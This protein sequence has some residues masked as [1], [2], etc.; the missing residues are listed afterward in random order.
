MKKYIVHEVRGGLMEDPSFHYHNPEEIVAESKEE[1]R[2]IYDERHS[3]FYF[4]G[5]I[6][7]ELGETDE[8]KTSDKPLSYFAHADRIKYYGKDLK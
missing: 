6:K 3:L 5:N 7:T 8:P 4:T 2:K 1:A